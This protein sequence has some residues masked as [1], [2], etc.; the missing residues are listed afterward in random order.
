VLILN[1]G[2]TYT[3]LEG[4]TIRLI[5]DPNSEMTDEEIAKAE[6]VATFVNDDKLQYTTAAGEFF[7]G[8]W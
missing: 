7:M 1:D 6:V 4:C 5:E 8:G 3:N 2:E